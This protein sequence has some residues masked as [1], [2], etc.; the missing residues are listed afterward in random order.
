MVLP[1]SLVLLDADQGCG[2]IRSRVEAFLGGGK[3]DA[4]ARKPIGREVQVPADRR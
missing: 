3:I 2:A 1:R 4:G